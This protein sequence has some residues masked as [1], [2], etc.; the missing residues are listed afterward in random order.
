[1]TLSELIAQLIDLEIEHGGMLVKLEV[2][3]DGAVH[4]SSNIHIG[5]Y[6]GPPIAEV[7]SD[8]R[9]LAAEARAERRAMAEEDSA[10]WEAHARKVEDDSRWRRSL[11]GRWTL[12]R[13]WLRDR[14]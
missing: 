6:F 2:G 11:R 4:T 3:G 13:L 8:E 14:C 1:M 7:V 10:M 5:L 12:L 9:D